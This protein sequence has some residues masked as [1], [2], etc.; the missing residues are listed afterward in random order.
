[1]ICSYYKVMRRRSWTVDE[2]AR[3]LEADRV[4]TWLPD[5]AKQ[6]GRARVDVT[7]MLVR[8]EEGR[9]CGMRGR[10][11]LVFMSTEGPRRKVPVRD[12]LSLAPWASG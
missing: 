3:L 1:V 6:L 5:I 12:R 2:V 9:R 7:G 11:L 8:L 4:T 10:P